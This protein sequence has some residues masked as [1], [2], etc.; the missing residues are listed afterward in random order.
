MKQ[1]LNF[2]N[3]SIPQNRADKSLPMIFGFNRYSSNANKFQIERKGVFPKMVLLFLFF[4]AVSCKKEIDPNSLSPTPGDLVYEM[5]GL[6]QGHVDL[7]YGNIGTIVGYDSIELTIRYNGNDP[8]LAFTDTLGAFPGKPRY[9]F[10]PEQDTVKTDSVLRNYW[11]KLP[12]IHFSGPKSNLNF[13]DSSSNYKVSVHY[14]YI[15]KMLAIYYINLIS[16]NSSTFKGKRIST[17]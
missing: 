11:D 2:P 6:Y 13:K 5:T 16:N 3:E 9:T 12:N 7:R 8:G 14:S 17:L 10:Y 4:G 15:D 1:T